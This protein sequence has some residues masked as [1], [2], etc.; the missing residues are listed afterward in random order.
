MDQGS[1]F[2]R[3]PYV[4]IV[5]W[6]QLRKPHFPLFEDQGGGQGTPLMMTYDP[7]TINYVS[8]DPKN[9]TEN[10]EKHQIRDRLKRI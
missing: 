1:Y 4:K 2:L 5:F 9:E 10:S 6:G 7:T 8:G 3:F